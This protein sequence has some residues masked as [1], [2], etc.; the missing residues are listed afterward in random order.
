[1]TRLLSILLLTLGLFASIPQSH[2]SSL[3]SYGIHNY[4]T[5]VFCSTREHI[6]N[7][8]VLTDSYAYTHYGKIICYKRS[9][10]NSYLFTG[11]QRDNE[12]GNYYLRARYYSPSMARFLS[13]DSY[14][15]TPAD[16]LSQNRY[17]YARGNPVVYVDP[18]GHFFGGFLLSSINILV[19]TIDSFSIATAGNAN[20]Y[21]PV[22]ISAY[23]IRIG[24]MLRTEALNSIAFA[25]THSKIYYIPPNSNKAK[26]EQLLDLAYKKYEYATRLIRMG[27]LFADGMNDAINDINAYTGFAKELLSYTKELHLVATFQEASTILRAELKEVSKVSNSLSAIRRH[28]PHI[29]ETIEHMNGLILKLWGIISSK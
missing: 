1:M 23:Y 2:S 17:L 18:S 20:F 29:T 11:K 7:S 28:T 6:D 14:D 3:L 25:I 15:G 24:M 5:D 27:G 9:F 13:R 16:P 26:N 8:G 10:E 12:T 21:V 19:S 4:I 22:A